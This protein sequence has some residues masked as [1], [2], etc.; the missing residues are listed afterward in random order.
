LGAGRVTLAIVADYI[1]PH[2]GD[3]TALRLVPHHRDAAH[4]AERR[5]TPDAFDLFSRRARNLFHNCRKRTQAS[6]TE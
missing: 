2:R 3:F 4:H 6:K 5:F 1:E